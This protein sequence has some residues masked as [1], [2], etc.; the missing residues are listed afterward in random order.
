M[1]VAIIIFL[2]LL[3]FMPIIYFTQIIYIFFMRGA[4]STQGWVTSSL[5]MVETYETLVIFIDKIYTN[6]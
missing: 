2:N 6:I 1:T 5:L 4:D 3:F